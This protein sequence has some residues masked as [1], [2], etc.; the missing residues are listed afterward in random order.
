MRPIRTF[1]IAGAAVALLASTAS[2]QSDIAP[3]TAVSFVGGLGSTT[4]TTGVALGGSLLFDVND[5]TALEAQGTYLDRGAGADALSVSGSFLVNLISGR[6][7]I[8]PYAAVGG[9]LYRTSFELANPAFLGPAGAQFGPGSTVC[10]APG[11][12]IGPGPGAGFG[13]GA[14]TCPANVAG[15]WGVGEMPGFYARRLGPMTVPP[16]GVWETRSFTDPTMSF[17]GGLRFNVNERLMVRPDV[18]ALVV[19]ADGETQTLTVFGVNVG[20]RF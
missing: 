18:R 8:V 20:Y 16:G 19:F 15:Y 9:G 5:R 17:G 6:E 1:I 13:P 3:R 10:P 12:G 14:G 2:A 11:T 4:S 7:R